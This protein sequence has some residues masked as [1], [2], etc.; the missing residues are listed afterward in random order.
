MNTYTHLWAAGFSWCSYVTLSFTVRN[1]AESPRG[2][3]VA[4]SKTVMVLFWRG[5]DLFCFC[6]FLWFSINSLLYQ[7]LW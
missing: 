2:S 1:R 6:R 7:R 5:L 4:G 3:Q